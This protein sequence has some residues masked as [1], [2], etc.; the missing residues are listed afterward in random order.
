MR[1][2]GALVFMA[3]VLLL[4]PAFAQG[5]DL[6]NPLVT[7][8]NSLANGVNGCSAGIRSVVGSFGNLAVSIVGV[9]GL[10]KAVKGFSKDPEG[11]AYDALK[12]S[13]ASMA[14]LCLASLLVPCLLPFV[15]F[16]SVLV[17][18]VMA[19]YQATKKA[20]VWW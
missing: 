11:I 12:A 8:A 13:F 16:A 18:L 19:F 15:P 7:V 14:L 1:H 5:V 6:G 10:D 17:G 9:C 4:S 2:T 3:A 20:Q